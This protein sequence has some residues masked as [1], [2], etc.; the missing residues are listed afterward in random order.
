V[1][2][3]KVR[4]AGLDYQV[5]NGGRSGDTTA[6]GVT[7]LSWYLRDAIDLQVLIIGLGSNDAMRG[8]PV[9][10]I[11]TNLRKIVAAARAHQ[12]EM[13]ILLWQLETFPNLGAEYGAE[14]E[15]LF[16]RIATEEKVLLLP[17]PLEGVAGKHE[18]NQEDG[19]HPT[20]AGTRIVADNIWLQLEPELRRRRAA[21]T[22][23][24]R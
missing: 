12:P 24:G 1:L 8:Q 18:L 23:E 17:F 4:A 16:P 20:S 15:A 3:Q 2:Q 7:R 13:S 6:G 21:T 19:I 14:F 10:E 5:I 9:A 22:A 11:E